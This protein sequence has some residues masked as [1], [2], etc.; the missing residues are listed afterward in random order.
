[1]RKR[2][3]RTR[4]FF[5][6]NVMS[7]FFLC[8]FGTPT[9]A[10]APKPIQQTLNKSHGKGSGT[11]NPQTKEATRSN[12]RAKHFNLSASD[13]DLLARLVYA[14]GRGEPYEG[15]MAIAAVVIN[16]VQSSQFPNT[17][18]GVIFAPNAFSPVKGGTLSRET[19]ETARKAVLDALNKKDPTKGALY[20]FNPNTATSSWI[21]SRPKAVRIENHIFAH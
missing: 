3:A 21:W 18:R 1:M 10:A 13:I 8:L 7:L 16:R 14:E 5:F 20:F 19:N 15:Q 17:V 4:F 11:A 6:F 12:T 9:G 2:E